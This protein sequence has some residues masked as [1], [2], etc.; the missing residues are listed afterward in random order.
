MN[1]C[2]DEGGANCQTGDD[3]AADGQPGH[4]GRALPNAVP[5]RGL[6]CHG[7]YEIG[8]E[9]AITGFCI[10]VGVA[11]GCVSVCHYLG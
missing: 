6:F 8:G 2:I 10:A 9:Y 5:Q 11:D 4:A 7:A 1:G 3:H